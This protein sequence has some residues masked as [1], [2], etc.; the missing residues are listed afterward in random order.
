MIA[1]HMPYDYLW[2]FCLIPL[3]ILNLRQANYYL[4][5]KSILISS[6]KLP[7]EMQNEE[8]QLIIIN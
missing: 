7:A 2:Q 6:K 4:K 5:T 3:P 8:Q 1:S